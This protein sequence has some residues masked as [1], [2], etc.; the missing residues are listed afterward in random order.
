MSM[1]TTSKLH[2]LN[3]TRFFTRTHHAL[4]S[5]LELSLSHNSSFHQSSASLPISLL[6]ATKSRRCSVPRTYITR[7]LILSDR[8][9]MIYD[10]E[11][12]TEKAKQPNLINLWLLCSLVVQHKLRICVSKL[13]LIGCT[14][15]TSQCQYL[16]EK[17]MSILRAQIFGRVLIQKVGELSG[18]LSSDL[19]SLDTV[20]SENIS[21][22]RGFRALF[23]ASHS[24][25]KQNSTRCY[26]LK[27][28]M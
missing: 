8:D 3:H 28:G 22:D 18:L 15:C 10:S 24:R 14:S 9:P 12:E 25:L 5:K 26:C 23:E 2:Q 1:A 6:T 27:L 20:V 16:M 7:P 21:R 11:P 19:G 4:K 17:V 13:A